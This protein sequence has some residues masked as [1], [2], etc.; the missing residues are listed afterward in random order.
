MRKLSKIRPRSIRANLVLLYVFS[1]IATLTLAVV[2]LLWALS[3]SLRDEDNDFIS[4]KI[5]VIT[6]ILQEDPNDSSALNQEIEWDR[7]GLEFTPYFARVVDTFGRVKMASAGMSTAV[8]NIFPPT[9]RAPKKWYAA[10]GKVYLLAS[11]LVLPKKT[12]A[13]QIVQVALDVSHEESIMDSYRRKMAIVFALGV[14]TSSL[15][16][17]WVT[18]KGLTPIEEIA[19]AA[20]RISLSRLDERIGPRSWPS[21]LK[22]LAGAFD[23]MLDRLQESFT[24]LSQFSAD[25]AHELR[26]PVGNLRG[27]AEVALSRP[28]SEDEYR[29]V[30]GSSLEEYSRI[31]DMI[32]SLLFLARAESAN[33]PLDRLPLNGRAEVQTVV[34]YFEPTALELGV[35]IFVYG[36][37]IIAADASLLRRALAN[38]VA[39]AIQNTPRDGRIDLTLSDASPDSVEVRVEDTGIGIGSEHLPKLFARFYQCDPA[40]RRDKHG[41]GLGLS[42]VKTIMDS[43]GGSIQLESV[44]GEGTRVILSFPKYPSA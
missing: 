19:V 13:A 8:P 5:R 1:A 23:A 11:A 43:H 26:T 21:E 38:I 10:N 12:G 22:E 27:E 31:S 32:E 30:I 17:A 39:N 16:S 36:D 35:S 24:R 6:L 42:I 29:Q 3:S 37:A 7:R 40:R 28:R 15:A 20:Q 2:F 44:L 34:D 4:E 33:L 41:S 18:R 25:I 9:G 14:L